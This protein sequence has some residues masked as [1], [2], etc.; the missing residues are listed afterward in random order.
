MR[1]L[2]LCL[3][4]S[5]CAFAKPFLRTS[6]PRWAASSAARPRRADRDSDVLAHQDGG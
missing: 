3:V 5:E 4:S 2:K 6:S 1:P